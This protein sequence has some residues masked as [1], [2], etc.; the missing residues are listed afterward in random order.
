MLNIHVPGLKVDKGGG[1]MSVLRT[2][3]KD[4][5]AIK[6]ITNAQYQEIY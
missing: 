3:L 1:N 4:N 6:V 2:V 5:P